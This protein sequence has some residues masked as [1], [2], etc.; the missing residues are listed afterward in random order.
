MDSQVI[1]ISTLK[2]NDLDML[3][4]EIQKYPNYEPF[5]VYNYLSR[6]SVLLKKV[7]ESNPYELNMFELDFVNNVQEIN[8]WLISNP[9]WTPLSIA[10]V[11]NKS[12]VYVY[13]RKSTT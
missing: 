5:S 2:Y 3:N 9:S 10:T 6:T 8:E 7:E 11:Q 4:K 13:R 1:S 12:W